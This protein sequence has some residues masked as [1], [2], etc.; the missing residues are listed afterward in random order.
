M[1]REVSPGDTYLIEIVEN[2][3]RRLTA[4]PHPVFILPCNDLE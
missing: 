1:I 4:N 2:V 3:L